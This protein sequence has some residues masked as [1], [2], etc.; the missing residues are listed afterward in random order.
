[1]TGRTTMFQLLDHHN[2]KHYSRNEL[3]L[4]TTVLALGCANSP[5]GKGRPLHNLVLAT[6]SLIEKPSRRRRRTEWMK[7]AHLPFLRP[8][9]HDSTA[10]IA[11]PRPPPVPR[12]LLLLLLITADKTYERQW[13][14]PPS[15]PS[16]HSLSASSSARAR[17]PVLFV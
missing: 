10:V 15:L 17:G 3:K 14:L 5:R 11:P 12:P 8:S 9:P 13:S 7:S 2:A 6:Q 1:M 16:P 4:K